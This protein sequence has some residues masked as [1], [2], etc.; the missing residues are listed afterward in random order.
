[1]F[2]YQEDWKLAER[3]T[4]EELREAF[5]VAQWP[6]FPAERD[7][8]VS[9]DAAFAFIDK[10]VPQSSI[11]IRTVQKNTYGAG[12]YMNL[13]IWSAML[14]DHVSDRCMY[15]YRLEGPGYPFSAYGETPTLAIMR[16]VVAWLVSGHRPPKDSLSIRSP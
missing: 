9:L 13:T 8:F 10:Y 5:R 1:M 15:P 12:Q 3:A 14:V 16:C 6:E 2:E 11:T 7:P 4:I